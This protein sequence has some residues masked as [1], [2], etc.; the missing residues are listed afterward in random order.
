MRTVRLKTQAVRVGAPRKLV[1][2]VVAAAGKNVGRSDDGSELV[3]FE[4]HWRG[5]TIKTIEAVDLDPHDRIGY[6]WV[7][8]P[9]RGVE[10]EIRFAAIKPD[11]TEMTYSGRFGAAQ[12]VGDLL[13]TVVFVRPVFNRLVTEHLEEGKRVAEKR[14]LRSRVHE[15]ASQDHGELNG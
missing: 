9:L 1:Y 7:K 13:R 14:A 12:S 3:E 11:V 2:E 6:R 15:R 10:E 8:G 4:T 5:R